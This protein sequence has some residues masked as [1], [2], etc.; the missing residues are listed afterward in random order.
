MAHESYPPNSERRRHERQ[1]INKQFDSFAA[2]AQE[3]VT[4]ISRSGIFIR[5]K[6]P[7]A[8]GAKVDL[9]FS[10]MLEEM[11]MFEGAGEVVRITDEGMGIE[12]RDLSEASRD[13]IERLVTMRES[14]GQ[15][16]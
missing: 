16:D 11:E 14:A 10:V 2:F 12:F 6:S 4:N 7:L 1:T 8:I 15:S 9:R 5:S 13:L 3:Y